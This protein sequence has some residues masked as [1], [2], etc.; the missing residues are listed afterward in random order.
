M[1]TELPLALFNS[2]DGRVRLQLKLA[3]ET[4]W[5]TQKQLAHLFEK[6]SKTISEHLNNI[7]QDAELS[8]EATIRKFRT[9]ALEGTRDVERLLDHYN[10]DA[11]LAVGYRVRSDRGVQFNEHN[12]LNDTGKVSR[13]VAKKLA[14]GEYQKFAEQRRIDNAKVISD[15]D[16]LVNKTKQLPKK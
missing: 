6:S 11:V 16:A 14:E 3:D 5:L 10:L 13:D 8:P 1:T 12:V 2:D 9:V 7:Y 15:F 4:L